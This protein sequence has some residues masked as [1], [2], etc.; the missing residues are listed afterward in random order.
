MVPFLA[1]CNGGGLI[2]ACEKTWMSL[3]FV[4]SIPGLVISGIIFVLIAPKLSNSSANSAL[5]VI[6][7][8][9]ILLSVL[10]YW[11]LIKYCQKRMKTAK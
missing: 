4:M 9:S 2:G 6:G 7:L 1:N 11:G 10:I 8:S 3:V 5:S